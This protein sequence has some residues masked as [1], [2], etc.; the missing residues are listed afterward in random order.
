MPDD[1]EKLVTELELLSDA[2]AEA[3]KHKD[4]LWRIVEGMKASGPRAPGY[5]DERGNLTEAGVVKIHKML[6]EGATNTQ[7][8]NFFDISV[9]AV[10]YRRNRWLASRARSA[11]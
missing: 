10:I 11:A 6:A 2:L 7:I 5:K 1:L 4:K 3:D 9:P 8:S